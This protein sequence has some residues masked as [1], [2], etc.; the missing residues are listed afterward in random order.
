M[1]ALRERLPL[2][3][4]LS[5]HTGERHLNTLQ[6]VWES[7]QESMVRR[8]LLRI[9]YQ[10][11]RSYRWCFNFISQSGLPYLIQGYPKLKRPRNDSQGFDR[12]WRSV[13]R[14]YNP[15]WRLSNMKKIFNTWNVVIPE[16]GGWN[17]N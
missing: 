17:S 5:I 2:D 13:G 3:W 7:V 9:L 1:I 8:R 10:R 6:P 15:D 12:L 16:A 14:S 11:I 4:A